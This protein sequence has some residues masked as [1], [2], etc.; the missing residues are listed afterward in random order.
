MGK[1]IYKIKCIEE[2]M[3]YKGSQDFLNSQANRAIERGSRVV[4]VWKG[5]TLDEVII[6]SQSD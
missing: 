4:R 6:S 1:T 5:K 3:G 2:S